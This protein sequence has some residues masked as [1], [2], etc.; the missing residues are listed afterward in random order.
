M[1]TADDIGTRVSKSIIE[2]ANQLDGIR[3]ELKA[4][5]EQ[6]EKVNDRRR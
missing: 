2:I 1:V 6:L 5:R 3:L 4:I